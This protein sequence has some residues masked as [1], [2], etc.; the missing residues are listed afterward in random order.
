MILIALCFALLLGL[1]VA[2]GRVSNLGAVQVRWGWLA[3][4]A[5]A[6]QAYLIFFPA[7]R[8][9]GLLSA[10]S[11]LLTASLML[12]LVVVWQNRHL[13]GVKLIGLG[14][15]LNFLVMAV[16]GGFMPIAPDTLAQIGYDGNAS[17]LE[18]GYI[19]GRT[20]NVVVEPGEASLWFLSD[21]MVVP[22]PFPIPTALSVGDLLIVVGV[23]VFLREA[24]FW[25]T[26]RVSLV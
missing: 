7:D 11:L 1:V 5:F 8:A 3:P 19:V 21:I 18:T 15:L 24:M 23:F 17:Q 9:G 12:L 6:M 26:A 22:R 4:L 14:L 13:R 25:H 2:G 16:N 10:R 20:K